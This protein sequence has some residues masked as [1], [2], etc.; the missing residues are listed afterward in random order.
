MHQLARAI[1]HHH[2]HIHQPRRRTQH[3]HLCR[4]S[5][6]ARHTHGHPTRRNTSHPSLQHR[7]SLRPPQH[8][9]Q[10]KS[11]LPP[12][13]HAAPTGVTRPPPTRHATHPKRHRHPAPNDRTTHPPRAMFA[14]SF[15][16]DIGFVSSAAPAAT[17]GQPHRKERTSPMHDRAHR[18]RLHRPRPRSQL[19]P[20]RP[21]DPHPQGRVTSA[22]PPS[23]ATHRKPQ[24]RVP[25]MHDLLIASSFVLMILAPCLIATRSPRRL[26]SRL[27]L[28]L[29]VSSQQPEPAVSNQKR[30]AH[31][32]PPLRHHLCP[33]TPRTLLRRL[34]R[35]QHP[36]LTTRRTERPTPCST[37]RLPSPPS[38]SCSSS[39]AWPPP[40][41]NTGTA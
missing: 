20:H 38:P 29:Q 8:T 35:R 10:A 15:R 12:P 31:A 21:P 17:G 25:A 22:I 28:A 3:R 13:C 33:S 23:T 16:G 7:P 11:N 6:C 30:A 2:V 36:G 40:G 19:P 18:R 1:P 41:V 4:T 26:G 14:P 24:K 9:S 32:R 27:S 37:P 5:L 34:P 39:P